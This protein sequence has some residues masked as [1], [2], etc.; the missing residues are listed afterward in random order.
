MEEVESMLC[1]AVNQAG[2]RTEATGSMQGPGEATGDVLI[3]C[4]PSRA[5]DLPVPGLPGR[6]QRGWIHPGLGTGR[7]RAWEEK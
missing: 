7:A 6:G 3:G 1:T 4:R 5:G 2:Q